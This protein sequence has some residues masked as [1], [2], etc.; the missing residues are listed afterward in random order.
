VDFLRSCYRVPMIVRTGDPAVLV[1]WYFCDKDAKPLD[2]DSAFRSKNWDNRYAVANDLGEQPG[3][4][5]WKNGKKPKNG[6]TGDTKSQ[7]CARYH[8]DWWATGLGPAES[9]GPFNADGV[10]LCCV[11]GPPISCIDTEFDVLSAEIIDIQGCSNLGQPSALE[12]IGPGLCKWL[13]NFDIT[14]PSTAA[15]AVEYTGSNNW[16]LTTTC[17]SSV[18]TATAPFVSGQV[19]DFTVDDD[20]PCCDQPSP[21]RSFTF[22]VTVP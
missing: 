22:R 6:F 1:D 10:P 7:R 4:R 9:V 19:V 8:A 16:E 15:A 17:D 2:V 11:N 18:V 20:F 3:P 13:C 12:R 5:P 21:P 14:G